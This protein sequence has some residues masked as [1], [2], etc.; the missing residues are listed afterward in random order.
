MIPLSPLCPHRG[1][2]SRGWMKKMPE[3]KGQCSCPS[4]MCGGRGAD[5][6]QRGSHLGTKHPPH[7]GALST[8]NT[9]TFLPLRARL[10]FFSTDFHQNLLSCNSLAFTVTLLLRVMSN[11][12]LPLAV[13]A[14]TTHDWHEITHLKKGKWAVSGKERASQC[15]RLVLIS[16]VVTSITEGS[17]ITTDLFQRMWLQTIPCEMPR[18]D[19]RA[20]SKADTANEDLKQG[21]KESKI[22]PRK[23]S[24]LPRCS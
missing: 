5:W 14:M 6:R 15:E 22:F 8:K 21:E 9:R 16:N 24:M 20:L 4:R 13:Q 23:W 1:E 2:D 12:F 18:P 19:Y 7:T 17:R 3:R 11:Y 10:L